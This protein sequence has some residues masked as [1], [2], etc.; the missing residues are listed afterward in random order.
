MFAR[1]VFCSALVLT[2][3]AMAQAPR[4]DVAVVGVA[5]A[6]G[7]AIR[8]F[9]EGLELPADAKARLLALTPGGYIGNAAE[10]ARDLTP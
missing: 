2:L 3:P 4:V 7:T 1:L 6:D 9:V 8:A 5:G 10:Q